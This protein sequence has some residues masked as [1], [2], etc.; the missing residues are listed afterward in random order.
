[1]S[2]APSREDDRIAPDA[3]AVFARTFRAGLS[4]TD[5]DILRDALNALAQDPPHP[6]DRTP[7]A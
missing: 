6:R 4:R 2:A 5:S 1:M 7:S 3:L